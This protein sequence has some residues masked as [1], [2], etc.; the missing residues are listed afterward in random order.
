MTPPPECYAAIIVRTVCAPTAPDRDRTKRQ[1]NYAKSRHLPTNRRTNAKDFMMTSSC[2]ADSVCVHS[3]V[4]TRV[5]FVWTARDLH[6]YIQYIDSSPHSFSTSVVTA[7]YCWALLS[8]DRRA[9][10]HAV[11]IVLYIIRAVIIGRLPYGSADGYP[12]LF[13]LLLCNETAMWNNCVQRM[14]ITVFTGCTAY[15]FWF[16]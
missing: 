3:P 5:W 6:I 1:I 8:A 7:Y 13:P 11:M 9:K 4:A 12:S 14:Y 10:G 2:V 15:P 16:I